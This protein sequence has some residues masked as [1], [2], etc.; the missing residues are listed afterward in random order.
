[1]QDTEHRQQIQTAGDQSDLRR[2]GSQLSRKLVDQVGV[3]EEYGYKDMI[4]QFPISKP[5]CIVQTKS[6]EF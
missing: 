3:G 4:H 6:H 2:E 1:M 5:S